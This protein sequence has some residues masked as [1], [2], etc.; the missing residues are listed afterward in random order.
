M[1]IFEE[2]SQEQATIVKE[3]CYI[4]LDSLR[5]IYNN[6]HHSNEDIINILIENE[7]DETMLM[8]KIEE[9][10]NSFKALTKNPNNLSR[11]NNTDLSAFRHILAQ[12]EDNYKENYPKAISNLWKRLFII[13]DNRTVSNLN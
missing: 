12:I 5:R 10:L 11:L 2:L 4:Q 1:I 9:K 13:E 3:I 8:D 6:Q 7:I